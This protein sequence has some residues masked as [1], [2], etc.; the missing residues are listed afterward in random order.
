MMAGGGSCGVGN[1]R[2]RAR[3]HLHRTAFSFQ[4]RPIAG[5]LMGLSVSHLTN[6]LSIASS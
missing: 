5:S 3:D 4:C 6:R 1:S 2:Q